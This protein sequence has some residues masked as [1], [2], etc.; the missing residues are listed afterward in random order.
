[1]TK[2]NQQ[3]PTEHVAVEEVFE[4]Q[5]HEI[6]FAYLICGQCGVP[7]CAEGDPG[8]AK[9]DTTKALA[10]ITQRRFFSYELS[11]TQPEDLQGFPV[12]DQMTLDGQLYKY[13]RFVPDE[14]LLRAQMQASILLLDEM[15]NVIAPKQAPAL[16]LVQNGLDN[17]WMYMACNS[18]ETAADG[19]PLTCP[20][21]NRIWYGL[22]EPDVEAYAW[23]N[24]HKLQFPPPELPI[25]PE[26]FMDYQPKWGHLVEDF[27]RVHPSIRNACPKEDRAAC[28]RPWP[29]QRQWSNLTKCLAGAE[30][31]GVSWQVVEKIT[32]G[33][34][35]EKA[36]QSF[37]KHVQQAS[38][39]DPA[40]LLADVDNFKL[41]KRYDI[42][43]ALLSSLITYVSRNLKNQEVIDQALAMRQKVHEQNEEL[44]VAF[45]AGL[46]MLLPQYVAKQD[47]ELILAASS[48]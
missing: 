20:F 12:V 32:S 28:S 30:A 16:N 21:I 35:G 13:M 42:A 19:Q 41:P 18:I 7:A 46:R 44:S 39:P 26:N 15:T 17:A 38:L 22:W 27:L 8:T 29:S 34:V 31:V 3:S 11:R 1:M 36:A 45:S 33:L 23:G 37:L 6:N 10:H 4:R 48:K 9:T 14:R 5:T 24:T 25:V 43:K 40:G 47:R 2:K